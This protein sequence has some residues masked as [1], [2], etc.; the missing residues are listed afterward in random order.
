[1]LDVSLENSDFLLGNRYSVVFLGVTGRLLCAALSPRQPNPRP[2]GPLWGWE[3]FLQGH[4]GPT[5][6]WLARSQVPQPR[7]AGLTAGCGCRGQKGLG[8]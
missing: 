8:P 6:E 5:E 3:L 4:W 7:G 2:R 1:M